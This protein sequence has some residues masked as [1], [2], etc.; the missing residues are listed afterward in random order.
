MAASRAHLLPE[1]QEAFVWPTWWWRAVQKTP[2]STI[3]QLSV[4]TSSR[5]SPAIPPKK[6]GCPICPWP[7]LYIH[8]PR[9]M[10]LTYDSLPCGLG[11]VHSTNRC[12]THTRPWSQIR[13]GPSRSCG[14]VKRIMG[15]SMCFINKAIFKCLRPPVL[16]PTTPKPPTEN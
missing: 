3:L 9:K 14:T 7:Q 5:L 4:E 2:P 11:S 16:P 12:K 10:T 6:H 8:G 15:Y 13:D 1:P